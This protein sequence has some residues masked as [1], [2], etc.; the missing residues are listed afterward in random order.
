MTDSAA[1]SVHLARWEEETGLARAFEAAWQAVPDSGVIALVTRCSDEQGAQSERALATNVIEA[2]ARHLASRGALVRLVLVPG[3]MDEVEGHLRACEA[4]EAAGFAVVSTS[5]GQ[6][7]NLDATVLASADVERSVLDADHVAVLA[8][9]L[10]HHVLSVSATRLE[11]ASALTP[12]SRRA[13]WAL[14]PRQDALFAALDELGQRLNPCWVAA[15]LSGATGTLIAGDDVDA[16]DRVT[17]HLMGLASVDIPT[18]G[19][20]LETALRGSPSAREQLPE[21]PD[22]FPGVDV[23]LCTQ[24][25]SC[26]ELCPTAAI[27]EEEED[28]RAVVFDWNACVR[29]GICIS[30]CP[31][32]ALTASTH[33][34]AARLVEPRSIELGGEIFA[35][36]EAAVPARAAMALGSDAIDPPVRRPSWLEGYTPP[37]RFEMARQRERSPEVAVPRRNLGADGKVRLIIAP[38]WGIQGNRTALGVAYLAGSLEA[39]GHPCHVIDLAHELRIHDPR[40]DA[41]L[42]EIGDP[43]PNG[44]VYGPQM[45]LMLHVMTPSDWPDGISGFAGRI[46]ES[47]ERDADRIAD[48]GALHGLTVAD[49]NAHYAFAL[50]AALKRRGCRVVLG[51]PSMS[52]YPTCDLALH[53]GIADAV[54]MGEGEQAIIALAQAQRDDGWEGLA[55][56]LVPG[57]TVLVNGIPQR[58][59]NFRNRELDALPFPDW[60]GQEHPPDFIPILAARGCVTK[61]SFCSEQTISPKFAQRSVADV[62][63]EMDALYAEYGQ[64]AFEFN[65]DLL[66]GNMKWLDAFCDALIERGSPYVW[67]GLCRPHRLDRPML[68]K[69]WDAGC[70]QM[71]YGVQHFSWRMLKM[72][73]RKEEPDPLMQVLDDTL[74]VGMQTYIDVI[75]GHPGENE[76]DVEI[77]VQTVRSLMAR[78]PNVAI[79]LNPFNYIYGSAIDIN[80]AAFDVVPEYFAE[81]LPSGLKHLEALSSKFVI[82]YTQTPDSRTVV[83]RVNRL[84]WTVFQARRPPKI[85]I[86][87]EELPFC[88]DNC[89]HCGVADIMKTA[90]VVPFKR[91][92]SSLRELAPISGGTVMFAVSEL[93]IRPDFI[94][95]IEAARAAQMHIIALV[96]NGRMFAYPE[97]TRRTVGA[98]LTHALVSVYGPTPRIH[99]SI[100]RTPKSFEQTIAGLRDLLQYPQVTVM[101]NSVITKKNYAYLPQMVELLAGLGVRNVNLSF[102]QIVGAADTYSRALIPRIRDVLTPLREAVDLGVSLGLNM[103]IGGLP[104]CVLK[105]YEHHFGVDDLT[106]IANSDPADNITERSPY[107]QAEAC[108]RCAYNAVCLGIQDEYLK[109]YGEEEL[110]PYHGR[111]LERRPESEIVRAMFPTMQYTHLGSPS[112]L[113]GGGPTEATTSPTPQ[114]LAEEP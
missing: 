77:T 6:A 61:C 39:A 66:N 80:P 18:T 12:A 110:D 100:T 88:N 46:V 47:A 50:A 24:C 48:P 101:T 106:T 72:M 26:V 75:L 65:D 49:S 19:M 85:P 9:A 112:S 2:A 4:L 107:T 10:P 62:L 97:F 74:D 15:A 55:E 5:S 93:T 69:M 53:G 8:P 87:D 21:L 79:N 41:E 89:L 103:G 51:G 16:V 54:V 13:L 86:L 34:E 33:Q 104:Y 67:Q 71:S 105:G 94:R 60:K 14:V 7:L 92:E 91:I 113:F 114:A 109:R 11:L 25:G 70:S 31:D 73:G 95:I 37:D 90:N 20:E 56:H 43:R 96:T 29:C 82:D 76:E 22:R 59:P 81:P 68:Q 44:G 42:S 3:D 52:H 111:R 32:F 40:L 38:N 102:V 99:Q 45:P 108:R 28:G 36:R 57:L 23:G 27:A 83:D 64:D 17:G 1:H 35:I 98:G 30:A 63:K 84:A 58:K 78:Y